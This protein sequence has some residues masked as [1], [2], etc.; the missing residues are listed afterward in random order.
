[1]RSIITLSILLVSLQPLFSQVVDSAS[2]AVFSF[3][4][5]FEISNDEGDYPTKDYLRDY[6]TKG[7]TRAH[8]EMYPILEECMTR[9]LRKKGINIEPFVALAETKSNAYGYPSLTLGKATK[10]GLYDQYLKIA[11]KDI[12]QVP[13]SQ[14]D[15]APGQA[16]KPVIMRCR[17]SLYD[18]NKNILKEA[19]GTFGSGEKVGDQYDIGVDLRQY[20]GDGRA[21]ELKFYEVCCKMA[22]LRA[23]ENF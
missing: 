15:A 8:E 12:G 4:L 7:K 5:D 2:V 21:Q 9:Q 11:L 18:A 16:V 3:S 22:F 19:E 17:I 14:L 6:G 10:T 23:L 20:Q 13:P 1:M